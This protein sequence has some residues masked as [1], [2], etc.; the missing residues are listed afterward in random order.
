M[1][2]FFFASS[3][4][5]IGIV[6]GSV[7]FYLRTEVKRSKNASLRTLFL[8]VTLNNHKASGRFWHLFISFQS[9]H[10]I[11]QTKCS[12]L[13]RI[14]N[15][16]NHKWTDIVFVTPSNF[17]EIMAIFRT[18]TVP[19]CFLSSKKLN[20]FWISMGSKMNGNLILVAFSVIFEYDLFR[21]VEVYISLSFSFDLRTITLTVH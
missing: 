5:F 11:K 18:I 16:P 3:V 7:R 9:T 2:L 8:S 1:F 14:F 15:I 6:C 10:L 19:S 17:V 4:R 13:S 20:Q 12:R 21:M